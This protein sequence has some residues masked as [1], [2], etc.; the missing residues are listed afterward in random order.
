[1]FLR[2][3]RNNTS[4]ASPS[5]RHG[6]DQG[7]DRRVGHHAADHPARGAELACLPDQVARDQAGDEVACDRDQADQAIE[8]HADIG[9]GDDEGAV[10]QAASASRRASDLL[11]WVVRLGV[12]ELR[13]AHNVGRPLAVTMPGAVCMD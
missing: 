4:K 2:L 11:A 10:H 7:I 13:M 5:T 6:P 9:A 12:G 8:P 3:A 1:M